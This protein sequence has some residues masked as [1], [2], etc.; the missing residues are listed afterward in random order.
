MGTVEQIRNNSVFQG[1]D[2]QKEDQLLLGDPRIVKKADPQAVKISRPSFW[3]LMKGLSRLEHGE[4][5]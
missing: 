5:N 4:F 2:L 3:Q 1:T